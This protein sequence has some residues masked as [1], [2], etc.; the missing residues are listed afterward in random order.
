M[1]LLSCVATGISAYPPCCSHFGP[2]PK[3]AAFR[4]YWGADL[5]RIGVPLLNRIQVPVW[6]ELR[7]LS[8][9]TLEGAEMKEMQ[10][11]LVVVG[12]MMVLSV[13]FARPLYDMNLHLYRRYGWTELAETWERRQSWWL[14][15]CRLICA[16]VAVGCFI[17]TL[18]S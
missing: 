4:P 18:M 11:A 2:R 3:G 9:P 6:S 13:A 14:P 12:I 15:T 10:V 7:I 16:A 5:L 8:N 1:P 17:A